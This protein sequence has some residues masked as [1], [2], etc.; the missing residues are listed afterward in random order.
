M[1]EVTDLIIPVLKRIQTDIAELKTGQDRLAAK[2]DGLTGRFDALEGYLTFSMGLT[3]RNTADIDTIREDI[4]EMR[5]TF[6]AG[7]ATP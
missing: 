5:R 7:E 4:K 6:V 3:S 2:V 1:S